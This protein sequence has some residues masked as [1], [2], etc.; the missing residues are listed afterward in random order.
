MK[1][2]VTQFYVNLYIRQ[3]QQSVLAV[4]TFPKHDESLLQ[5]DIGILEF[6]SLTDPYTGPI[7]ETYQSW[8]HAF[9]GVCVMSGNIEFITLMEDG[10]HL[11]FGIDMRSK[12]APTLWE[13]W[14]V[15]PI[16]HQLKISREALYH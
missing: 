3:R 8:H 12:R 16:P 7:Q 15:G 5:V 4:F 2:S 14:Y 11:G 10:R 13:H 6:Q 1:D 9:H